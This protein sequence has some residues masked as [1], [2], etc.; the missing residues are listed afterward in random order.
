MAKF[1]YVGDAKS[2]K[3]LGYD[4]PEGESVEVK[5]EKKIVKLRGNAQFKE[6]KPKAKPKAAPKPSFE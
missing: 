6:V 2:T 5:E 1:I 3:T 4:F